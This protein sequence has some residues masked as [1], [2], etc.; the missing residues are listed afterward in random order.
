M[1]IFQMTS[2]KKN[3]RIL[4]ELFDIKYVDGKPVRVKKDPLKELKDELE[5]EE[6][7]NPFDATKRELYADLPQAQ[8]KKDR[9]ITARQMNQFLESFNERRS[10]LIE[11]KFELHQLKM[12][13]APHCYIVYGE[14]T[15][16]SPLWRFK[17]DYAKSSITTDVKPDNGYNLEWKNSK[18]SKFDKNLLP[19]IYKKLEEHIKRKKQ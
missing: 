18:F 6:D 7:A 4:E 8:I 15:D 9:S 14:K 19:E 11:S 16:G 3:C 12:I 17:W 13:N 5:P 10:R 2:K 1:E